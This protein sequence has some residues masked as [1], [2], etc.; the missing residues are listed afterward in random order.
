MSTMVVS[1]VPSASS[2]AS[3]EEDGLGRLGFSDLSLKDKQHLLIRAVYE[4]SSIFLLALGRA[5]V[6]KSS[7]L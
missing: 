4:G 1:S 2:S 3:F 5:Y 7:L 6:M